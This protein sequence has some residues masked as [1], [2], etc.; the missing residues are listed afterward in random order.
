MIVQNRTEIVSVVLKAMILFTLSELAHKA[1]FFADTWTIA[2]DVFV[3]ISRVVI[4]VWTS[5]KLSSK[6]DLL[7]FLGLVFLLSFF[8][9]IFLGFISLM[10]LSLIERQ[11]LIVHGFIGLSVTFPIVLAFVMLLSGVV[12]MVSAK[13]K[14]KNRN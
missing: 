13:L 8:E 10:V 1:L 11:F 7:P 3:I 2:A 9:Y 5:L 6:I 4:F 12:F 14:S